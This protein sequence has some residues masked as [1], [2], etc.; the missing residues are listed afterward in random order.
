MPNSND[1][2]GIDFYEA[3]Q[4]AGDSYFLF[5]IQEGESAGGGVSC[6]FWFSSFE[7]LINSIR[8]HMDFWN[9]RNGFDEASKALSKIIDAHKESD[10]LD[11]KLLSKLNE[12]S[13]KNAGVRLW[14]WGT[15]EDLCSGHEPFSLETRSEFRDWCNE[16]DQFSYVT[17]A[18]DGL[19]NTDPITAIEQDLFLEY[20]AQTPT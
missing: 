6:Y 5:T 16:T 17:N 14:E 11:S 2:S 13:Q 3:Q 10:I 18:D 4:N 19:T 8:L 15:Y 9:W 12:Y 1:H 7:Q 20:L